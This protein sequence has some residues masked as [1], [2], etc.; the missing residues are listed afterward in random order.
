M[1]TKFQKAA[2][3][4]AFVGALVASNGAD[5]DIQTR[6]TANCKPL[7]PEAVDP[8][9]QKSKLGLTDEYVYKQMQKAQEPL[10]REA[11][12]EALAI[13]LP[14]IE[15]TQNKAYENAWV[16][17]QVA[18]IYAQKKAWSKAIEH[19]REAIARQALQDSQELQLRQNL[20]YFYMSAE[21]TAKALE[22]ALEYF[23]HA[24]APKPDMYAL[25]SSLY[26]QAGK[27]QDAICPAYLAV[28]RSPTV[29]KPWLQLLA[30]AHLE[31]K[32]LDGTAVV[33]K[34]TLENF[35]D[36]KSL[37]AQLSS[38][39]LQQGKDA[40][41]LAILDLAYLKG[42]VDQEGQIRN[43]AGLYANAGV[44][45]KAA[46]VLEKAVKANQIP[47]SEKIWYGIGQNYSI[48]REN[49]K[50]IA[51]YGEAA[52]F[53]NDGTYFVYQG[54]IY[55]QDEKWAEAAAAFG[56]ALEKGGL[57]DPGR[58]YLNLG[59]A[60]YHQGKI[61]QAMANLEKATQYD[62]ARSAASSWINFINSRRVASE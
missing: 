2:L 3:A 27:H 29:K 5:A 6:Y 53:A 57:K 8:N 33:L 55:A 60:Q 42:F 34:E 9:K 45:F 44:P 58:L 22:A 43:L 19:A 59:I 47:A 40:D 4:S 37:W 61:Q 14:L 50:A 23:K 52:K 18:F 24:A 15:R 32:D 21:N 30:A 11:H 39:Y 48:A 38:I 25:L 10:G 35:P 36:D 16:R 31:I 7:S 17:M 62:R 49:G 28:T 1:F 20:V 12:D 46:Q 54:E 51:A 41:A 56:K 26:F 13:V